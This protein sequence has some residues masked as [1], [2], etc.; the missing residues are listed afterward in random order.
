MEVSSSKPGPEQAQSK[1]RTGSEEL[2]GLRKSS[3]INQ[4]KAEPK[5]NNIGGKNFDFTTTT[6]TTTTVDQRNANTSCRSQQWSENT[7]PRTNPT[8]TLSSL[9]NHKHNPSGRATDREETYEYYFKE[10]PGFKSIVRRRTSSLGS[11][12]RAENTVPTATPTRDPPDRPT[13]TGRILNYYTTERDRGF[14]STRHRRDSSNG[15]KQRTENII[16]RATPTRGHRDSHHYR[17]RSLTR[18]Q[19]KR[20][21]RPARKLSKEKRERSRYRRKSSGEDGKP[22]RYRRALSE[23]KRGRRRYRSEPPEEQGGRRRYR[24]EL[25]EEHSERRSYRRAPSE[26]K[27][28]RRRYRSESSEEERERRHISES[29]EESM[30]YQGHNHRGGRSGDGGNRDRERGVVAIGNTRG[31]TGTAASS[32]NTS[33]A[34]A[35]PTLSSPA[36]SVA[37][38]IGGPNDGMH[39]PTHI[40]RSRPYFTEQQIEEARPKDPGL[41]SKDITM[42]LSVCTWIMQVG[43]ILRL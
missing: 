15:S 38:G 13:S 3:T 7:V 36:S 21:F 39:H 11:Q 1:L 4:L 17:K 29:S 18:D 16:A 32:S 6:T 43:D 31:G 30:P 33:P 41:Q 35:S 42:R 25:S 5:H 26:A 8:E 28:G 27:R 23:E 37:Y 12:Q 2:L 40:Q 19:D 10:R 9:D 34:L 22:R 14:N 20:K 24:S